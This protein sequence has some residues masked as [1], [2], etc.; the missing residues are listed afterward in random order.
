MKIQILIVAAMSL[1]GTVSF[2]QGRA[3][4]L[5]P[6]RNLKQVRIAQNT[7]AP[8]TQQVSSP[9]SAGTSTASLAT[10]APAPQKKFTFTLM[11]YTS[12]GKADLQNNEAAP[13][14]FNRF[15]GTYHLSS[16]KS[17]LLRE[18]A[19][20]N[21]VRRTSQTEFHV[22][23]PFIGY[24][25]SKFAVLPMDWVITIQPRLYLPLG[26]KGRFVTKTVGSEALLILADKS[27]GKF[28]FEFMGFYQYFNNTQ[29]YYW[30]DSAGKGSFLAKG[31]PDWS[32]FIEGEVA[33]NMTEKLSLIHDVYLTAAA[34]RATPDAPSKMVNKITNETTVS[35]QLT[36]AFNLKAAVEN[37]AVLDS[38]NAADLYQDKDISYNIYLKLTL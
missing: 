19:E 8:V 2:A 37:N 11:N 33:Y 15:Q 30:E 21:Y 18:D 3:S 26:E 38:Q 35:Y 22:V 20:Y 7:V 36:K 14:G 27:V 12:V 32:G 34:A 29:D 6:V 13:G 5:R 17:F 10:A 24:T 16:T 9:S 25:D 23:D 4:S 28:D 1:V 31:N